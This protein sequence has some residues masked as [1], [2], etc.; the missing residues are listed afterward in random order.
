MQDD[1][2]I[3]MI[4]EL[5]EGTASKWW[6]LFWNLWGNGGRKCAT[7]RLW[8]DTR[9]QSQKTMDA[10]VTRFLSFSW[11]R[12]FKWPHNAA[13]VYACIH[14]YMHACM[15]CIALHYITLHTY[16]YY[17]CGISAQTHMANGR[18]NILLPFAPG[19]PKT[20]AGFSWKTKT[21]HLFSWCAI[22]VFW[23]LNFRN[24][25]AMDPKT[26]KVLNPSY[27]SHTPV[28]L[29]QILD[30]DHLGSIGSTNKVQPTFFLLVRE[31]F[32][33]ELWGSRESGAFVPHWMPWVIMACRKM[34]NKW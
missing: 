22:C 25:K 23:T 24:Q 12:V 15:H 5:S 33:S 6:W 20:A 26:F 19:V 3:G 11:W 21:F 18:R 14:T 28:I 30:L 27:S 7:G 10:L 16:M 13:Y 8:K 34:A 17:F 31:A 2:S 9:L 29:P 1:A 4:L 32:G